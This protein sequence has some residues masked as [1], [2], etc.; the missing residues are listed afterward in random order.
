MMN[1]KNW[2][3]VTSVMLG[4]AG[5]MILGIS[6]MSFTLGLSLEDKTGMM[7][8]IATMLWVSCS[9][10]QIA[11]TSRLSQSDFGFQLL[12]WISYGIGVPVGAF[13]WAEILP[14]GS[15]FLAWV[16]YVGLSAFIEYAPERLLKSAYDGL[17]GRMPTARPT[18]TPT[19]EYKPKGPQIPV[20]NEPTYRNS[21]SASTPSKPGE[22]TKE[23]WSGRP[24]LKSERDES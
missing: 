21:R 7:Y 11:G 15:G 24:T 5:L 4:I 14:F 20:R 2:N 6:Y 8:W 22:L 19:P 12:V 17:A 16:A 13:A 23:W 10:V 1:N 3:A 9:L 18:P